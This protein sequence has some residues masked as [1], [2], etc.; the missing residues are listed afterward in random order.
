MATMSAVL[1]GTRRAFR[2]SAAVRVALEECPECAGARAV[3]RGDFGI[4]ACLRCTE[5]AEIEW[6]YR[7]E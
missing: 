4:D 1:P 5:W 3:M 6:R 2:V 7:D